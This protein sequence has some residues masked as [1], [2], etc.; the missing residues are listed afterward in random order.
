[1]DSAYM[2]KMATSFLEELSAIEKK[3]FA[4]LG[5]LA[6]GFSTLG[7]LGAQGAQKVSLKGLGRA[8]GMAYRKGAAGGGGVL[9]GL[10]SLA[11]SPVGAAGAAAGLTGL[12]AYG[13]YR[14][15]TGGSNQGQYGR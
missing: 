6:K 9:G 3:G 14:M 15:L 11:G 10:K 1:M 12:G 8:G 5:Y 13:G 4:P 7:R 2:T